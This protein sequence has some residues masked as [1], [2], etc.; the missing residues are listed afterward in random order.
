MKRMNRRNFFSRTIAA[1]GAILV[2]PY[3]PVAVPYTFTI[4]SSPIVIRP[5]K[6][7]FKWT[8]EGQQL[9]DSYENQRHQRSN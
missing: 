5:R 8:A 7:K 9:L 2:G 6:L 1:I 4:V 3:V